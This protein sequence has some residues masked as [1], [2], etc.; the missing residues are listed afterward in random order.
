[1]L[2][3][4]DMAA[5]LGAEVLV[6]GSPKQRQ[7]EPGRESESQ[8]RACDILREVAAAA[9]R[10]GVIYC[11]EPL[12]RTETN[13]INTLDEAA[14]LVEAV[15]SPEFAA[16]LDCSATGRMGRDPVAE[17]TAHLPGGLRAPL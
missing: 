16:M 15:G 8:A 11:I 12:A 1:M 10:A 2:R 17:I 13:F 7:L 9:E 14:D 5:A 4:V 3:L 6:H